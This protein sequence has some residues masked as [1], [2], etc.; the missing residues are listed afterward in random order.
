MI[1]IVR[2]NLTVANKYVSHSK[3]GTESIN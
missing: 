3:S 2:F 1:K